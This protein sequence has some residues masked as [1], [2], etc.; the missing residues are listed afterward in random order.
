MHTPCPQKSYS[1]FKRKKK[2]WQAE[3]EIAFGQK[4]SNIREISVTRNSI[5]KDT[6]DHPPIMKQA[7]AQGRD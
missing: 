1:L 3:R 6:K 2:G 4:R 5:N 7:G